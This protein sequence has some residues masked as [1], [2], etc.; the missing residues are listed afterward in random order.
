MTKRYKI[1]RKFAGNHPDEI[2][3]SGLTEEEAQDHCSHPGTSSATATSEE[4]RELTRRKGDWM[5]CYYEE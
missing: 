3:K 1:V 2:V 4:A 5:D